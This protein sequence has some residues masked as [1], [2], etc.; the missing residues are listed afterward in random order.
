MDLIAKQ[1]DKTP[2][3]KSDD[4]HRQI[5]LRMKNEWPNVRPAVL[6][7]QTYDLL[8]GLR[9]FRHRQRNTYGSDLDPARVTEL[10]R[11]AVKLPS[12]LLD[13]LTALKR[14]LRV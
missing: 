12:L 11:E 10:A 5:L 14:N 7:E 1:I 4:W 9:S 6:S 8:N 3:P 13:D 2:I